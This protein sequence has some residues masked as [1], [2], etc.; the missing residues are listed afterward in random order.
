MLHP[1]L[2]LPWLGCS[3]RVGIALRQ[4]ARLIC[5]AA[6]VRDAV[7]GDATQSHGEENESIRW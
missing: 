7:D 2:A 6:K 1:R 5:R 3:A 4:D